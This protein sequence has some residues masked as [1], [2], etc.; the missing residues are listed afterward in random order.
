MKALQLISLTKTYESGNS[1][2]RV[3][4]SINLTI[5][6]NEFVSIIG[7]S[8]SGKTTL[9]NIISKNIIYETSHCSCR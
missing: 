4:D 3:L 6:P 2:I 8:G 9:L 5:Y 1:F 7:S